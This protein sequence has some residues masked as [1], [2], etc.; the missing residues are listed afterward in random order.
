MITNA[1]VK[2]SIK[3]S[4]GS[5]YESTEVGIA[6]EFDMSEG[7]DQG[8]SDKEIIDEYTLMAHSYCKEEREKHQSVISEKSVFYKNDTGNP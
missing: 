4:I 8:M 3:F 6:I 5:G 1:Q 2:K 7:R